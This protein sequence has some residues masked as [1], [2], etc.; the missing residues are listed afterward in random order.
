MKKLLLIIGGILLLTSFYYVARIVNDNVA[1]EKVKKENT[2]EAYDFYSNNFKR[3]LT[4]LEPSREKSAIKFI[5]ENIS[6]EEAEKYIARYKINGCCYDHYTHLIKSIAYNTD[7][8]KWYNF[9]LKLPKLKD[10]QKILDSIETLADK[11][12]WILTRANGTWHRYIQRFPKGIYQKTA[13]RNIDNEAWNTALKINS[14]YSFSEYVRNFPNGRFSETA[15]SNIHELDWLGTKQSDNVASYNSFLDR[16]PNTKYYSKAIKLFEDRFVNDLISGVCYQDIPEK[17]KTN[18][19]TNFNGYWVSRQLYN[20]FSIRNNNVLGSSFGY[21]FAKKRLWF[22]NKKHI[23]FI[24]Y[25]KN[26]S[27][28][29]CDI[30]IYEIIEELP[31]EIKAR[32]LKKCIK[33]EIHIFKKIKDSNNKR[34]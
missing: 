22:K 12:L 23:C 25:R 32:C 6:F 28:A 20:G 30:Y 26:Y 10:T 3:H 24:I 1:W 18:T 7:D 11:S 17:L 13:L 21:V 8:Y 16:Y 4:E 33:N 27:G 14:K 9:Y 15:K 31:K 19:I 29:F 34:I 5:R 2:P